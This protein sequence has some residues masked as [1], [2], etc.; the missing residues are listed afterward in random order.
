MSRDE[1]DEH[2]LITE[3][4]TERFGEPPAI[5]TDPHLMWDVLRTTFSSTD[6]GLSWSRDSSL[7]DEKAHQRRSQIGFHQ[8]GGRGL[9][10]DVER[11]AGIEHHHHEMGGQ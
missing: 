6:R 5:L 8:A 10:V 7:L 4:W 9:V 11:Q 3:L 2:R 1:D